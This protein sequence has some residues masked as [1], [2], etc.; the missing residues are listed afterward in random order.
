MKLRNNKTYPSP[1]KSSKFDVNNIDFSGIQNYNIPEQK[2]ENI[3][4][5]ENIIFNLDKI[6]YSGIQNYKT[7]SQKLIERMSNIDFLY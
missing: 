1:N 4:V 6:D 2:L 5:K 7:S 3:I